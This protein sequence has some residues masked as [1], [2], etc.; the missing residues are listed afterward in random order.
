MAQDR[1]NG[2]PNETLMNS[3]LNE[4]SLIILGLVLVSFV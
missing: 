4:S 2:A 3:I 1:M